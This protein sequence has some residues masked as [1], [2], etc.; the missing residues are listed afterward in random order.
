MRHS[1]TVKR[2]SLATAFAKIEENLKV[3]YLGIGFVWAWIYCSF[4]TS[5]VYPDRDGISINAD[6]SWLVSATVV[7]AAMIIGGIVLRKTDLSTSKCMRVAAPVLVAFGTVLSGI[8]P[9]IGIEPWLLYCTSG[10]TTGIGTALIC[11]MWGD[12]LSRLEIEQMEIAVPAASLVT[13]LC[14]LVF[15]YIQ[16]VPGILA[17]A[18]LPL[19]SGAL[20]K[21]FYR[22]REG[23]PVAARIVDRPERGIVLD[24]V[25]IAVVLFAAYLLVGCLGAMSESEDLVQQVSGVDVPTLIGSGFGLVL[26]ICFIMF[27]VRIDF[28]S[29]FRWLAPLLVLSV[30][31]FP[32]QEVAPNFLSTT[33]ICIADTSMQVI[34]YIYVIGLAKRK[35]MSPVLGI[36]LTQGFVQLGVLVGNL[37]GVWAGHAVSEGTLSVFVLALGLICLI[38][39]ATM[40]VPQGAKKPFVRDRPDAPDDE[41]ETKNQC[42]RLA[43]RFGLSTREQQILEY[44]AKG[45]S[46][47][48]IRDELILSKN[49][50]ATHVKHIYQKLNVHSRQ[51]LLDL[52]EG[53]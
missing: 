44:L 21:L 17:V 15:P 26:A 16:G 12:A 38:S 51:E 8:V 7:V 50:V 35:A 40:L 5:A 28:S 29:L 22:E 6:P 41:W 37:L 19:I 49:T 47:P 46:Q 42:A 48:Y 36:G 33:I 23:K 30:A 27:S 11:L 18:S 9:L 3:R 13:L 25:R 20:L 31:L 4:E 52:F 10:I 2:N 14:C 39:F 34:A 1:T 32:W 24:L 45:R 43:E 53:R